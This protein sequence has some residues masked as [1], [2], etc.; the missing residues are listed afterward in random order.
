MAAATADLSRDHVEPFVADI[1]TRFKPATASN[2]YRALQQFFTWA[3]DER[4]IGV[5]PM[6]RMKPPNIPEEPQPVVSDGHI[7]R[8]LKAC[9]GKIR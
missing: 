2:R 5:S 1:L 7:A 3:V 9:E 8:L 4:E 6:A